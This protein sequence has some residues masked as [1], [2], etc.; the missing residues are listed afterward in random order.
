MD[1]RPGVGTDVAVG[2]HVCHNIVAQAPLVTLGILEIDIIHVGPKLFDLC[3]GDGQPQFGL[4]LGQCHPK[5]APSAELPSRPPKG[6]HLRRGVTGD[7]GIVVLDVV[8]IICH[9][10]LGTKSRFFHVTDVAY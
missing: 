9:G 6:D 1:D 7:K 5:P 4:G 8:G 10:F 2:M 3:P